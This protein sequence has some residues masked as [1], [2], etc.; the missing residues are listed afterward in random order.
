MKKTIGHSFRNFLSISSIGGSLLFA[1]GSVFAGVWVNANLVGV[2][3]FTTQTEHFVEAQD[4]SNP[5]SCPAAAQLVL[6]RDDANNWKMVH[7]LIMR[8]LV[9]GKRLQ[10][11][12]A[13]CQAG[14]GA[15]IIDG[16]RILKF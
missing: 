11:R 9:S 14:S 4:F 8:A 2:R 5:D 1:S 7:E 15:T 16:A 3:A 6:L 13:G 12:T 10:V